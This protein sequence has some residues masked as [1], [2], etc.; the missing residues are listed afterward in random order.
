ELTWGDL[1][2]RNGPEHVTAWGHFAD[3]NRLLLRAND[4]RDL[5]GLKLEQQDRV[6]SGG[7]TYLHREVP[8]HGDA[9][10]A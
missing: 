7:Y 5:C 9:G 2:S 10:P 3:V 6:W 4:L 1:G 8:Y